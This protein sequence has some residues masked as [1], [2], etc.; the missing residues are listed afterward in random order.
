MPKV[1]VFISSLFL[2]NWCFSSDISIK[3]IELLKISSKWYFFPS[4]IQQLLPFFLSLSLSPSS[5]TMQSIYEWLKKFEKGVILY[6]VNLLVCTCCRSLS[7]LLF[8]KC[9]KHFL[10]IHFLSFWLYMH[11]FS[12]F[13]IFVRKEPFAGSIISFSMKIAFIT[14]STPH[15]LYE[16]SIL[17][18][19]L[20]TINAHWNG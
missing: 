10:F 11:V 1:S 6:H 19:N 9:H 16:K 18:S 7:F 20:Y 15:V 13:P 14:Q 5:C 8:W 4:I 3:I 2:P 12:F 17:L